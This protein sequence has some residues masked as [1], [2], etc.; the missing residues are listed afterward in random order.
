MNFGILLGLIGLGFAAYELWTRPKPDA[1]APPSGGGTAPSSP[2]GP[3]G[4][5]PLQPTNPT[6]R[7]DPNN[8]VS[9]KV[10]ADA[11][12][13]N[14]LPTDMADAEKWSSYYISATLPLAPRLNLMRSVVPPLQWPE[15]ARRVWCFLVRQG[16]V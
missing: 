9:K 3:S 6:F 10:A 7:Y 14:M 16:Q 1:L 2:L 15:S 5:R 8:P 12:Y 11:L 4:P 13:C